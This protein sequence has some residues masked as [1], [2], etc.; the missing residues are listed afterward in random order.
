MTRSK[1][2]LAVDQGCRPPRCRSSTRVADGGARP[3]VRAGGEGGVGE[4][5]SEDG[6]RLWSWVGLNDLGGLS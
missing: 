1:R 5:A 6:I 2:N 3:D 4:D